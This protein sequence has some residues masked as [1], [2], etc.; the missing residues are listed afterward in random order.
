MNEPFTEHEAQQAE[1]GAIIQWLQPESLTV[2]QTRAE[3]EQ[4]EAMSAA[5]I[6]YYRVKSGIMKASQVLRA[7]LFS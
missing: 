2:I 3:G 4:V 1:A 5:A 6:A 7:F